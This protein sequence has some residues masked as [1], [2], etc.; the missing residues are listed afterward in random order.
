M[1]EL[2]SNFFRSEPSG[3]LRRCLNSDPDHIVPGTRHPVV[4]FIQEALVSLN[5][6]SSSDFAGESD[7]FGPKTTAAVSA[8]KRKFIARGERLDNNPIVGTGTVDLLD[9]LLARQQSGPVTPP[10]PAPEP[11]DI[12]VEVVGAIPT[13]R[14]AG[15]ETTA[16]QTAVGVLPIAQFA[17]I[18]GNKNLVHKQW[19]GGH[20]KF[21]TDPKPKILEFIN[22][23]LPGGDLPF[24]IL[25]AGTSIGGRVV[26]DV[27]KELTSQGKP[28]RYLGIGDAAFDSSSDPLLKA[29]VKASASQNI[30]QSITN[31]AIPGSEFHGAVN[32]F[33][34]NRDLGQDRM[35][36]KLKRDLADA[37]SKEELVDFIHKTAVVAA[38]SE[39]RGNLTSILRKQA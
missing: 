10:K 18:V 28:L 22:Q 15:E 33:N 31:D 8:F 30:F 25:L 27:A 39:I 7:F 24:R 35:F 21:G 20:P 6:A 1:K 19:N 12:L 38:Y 23:S 14:P 11:K 17:R 4:F 37:S 26:V 32:S 5:E 34:D 36:S 13:K 2:Q 29:G 16:G 9:R 3:R